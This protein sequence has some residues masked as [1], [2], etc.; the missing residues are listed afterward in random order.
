[1]TQPQP[2]G[3]HQQVRPQTLN[4]SQTG[5]QPVVARWNPAGVY[6]GEVEEVKE[7]KP[8]LYFI[9][10]VGALIL[11]AGIFLP[12][13]FIK[14][15][16]GFFS[17][18]GA[19]MTSAT[20]KVTEAMSKLAALT[21]SSTTGLNEMGDYGLVPGWIM[22]VLALFSL[23]AAV[24]GFFRRVKV[25]AALIFGVGIVCAFILLRD[26]TSLNSK[27]NTINA[28]QTENP[29]ATTLSGT[30]TA[31]GLAFTAAGIAIIILG[32]AITFLLFY[33][34]GGGA[35]IP[36]QRNVTARK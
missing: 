21:G 9:P 11:L 12:W 8:K 33:S 27:L 7:G 32:G 1:M 18:N 6:G 29:L 23:A 3:N 31:L 2:P 20:E 14:F 30:Q 19:G 26:T 24:G 5:P 13:F 22:L 16:S 4:T 17:M 25:N 36:V 28:F 35:A 10:A 15:N 34:G